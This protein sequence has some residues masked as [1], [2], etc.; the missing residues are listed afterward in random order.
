M[1]TVTITVMVTVTVTEYLFRQHVTSNRSEPSCTQH[2]SADPTEHWYQN[3]HRLNKNR[4]KAHGC[5][6]C[7]RRKCDRASDL[8]SLFSRLNVW[9]KASFQCVYII[10]KHLERMRAVRAGLLTRHLECMR[11]VC[12]G[13]LTRH[14]ACMRTVCAGRGPYDRVK[15][16]IDMFQVCYV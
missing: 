15:D 1:V 16:R 3:N 8:V 13:L 11:A 6:C 14:F 9:E 7:T 5:V 2:P 10:S 12:A 4:N